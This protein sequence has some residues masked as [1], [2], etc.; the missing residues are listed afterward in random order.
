MF[1]LD[2]AGQ[3]GSERRASLLQEAR[4]AQLIKEA[5]P[6]KPALIARLLLTGGRLLIAV[7]EKMQ[8]PYESARP[9]DPRQIKQ[10]A[11]L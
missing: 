8:A 2:R 11:K 4:Q 9:V 6:A 7:G 1:N 5:K 3:I 10:V